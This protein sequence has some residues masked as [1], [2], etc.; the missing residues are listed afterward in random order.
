MS[1]IWVGRE[2]K[3]STKISTKQI[4]NRRALAEG[5]PSACPI[6]SQSKLGLWWNSRKSLWMQINKFFILFAQHEV[7]GWRIFKTILIKLPTQ[8]CIIQY[9]YN[10][11]SLKV[12]SSIDSYI[13]IDCLKITVIHQLGLHILYVFLFKVW[14]ELLIKQHNWRKNLS[15]TAAIRWLRLE[16]KFPAKI[17]MAFSQMLAIRLWSN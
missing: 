10:L 4:M 2:K 17:E 16:F 5:K 13:P 12:G 3:N 14:S 8:V 9:W 11:I 1:T 15:I 6:G 7:K